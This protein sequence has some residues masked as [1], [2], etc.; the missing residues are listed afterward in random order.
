MQGRRN[1]Y[2]KYIVLVNHF[3]AAPRLI[4]K[5]TP[6]NQALV[7]VFPNESLENIAKN[8]HFELSGVNSLIGCTTTEHLMQL[9]V[10]IYC[11]A[12]F[13]SKGH[14]DETDSNFIQLHSTY[15]LL[16]LLA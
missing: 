8:A 3:S 13:A 10:Q 4:N 1:R 14:E 2:R 16:I 12:R 7:T 6:S 15:R 11:Q 5:F 9:F